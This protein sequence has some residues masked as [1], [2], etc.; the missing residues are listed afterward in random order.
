MVDGSTTM[1]S[2]MELS[3][4]KRSRGPS[5][6][7]SSDISCMSCSMSVPGGI[8]LATSATMRF[9]ASRTL[10]R[11]TLSAILVRSRAARSSLSR[12]IRWMRRRSSTETCRVPFT[13]P[14]GACAGGAL[15]ITVRARPLALP[16][17]AP[18]MG[19]SIP[20]AMVAICWPARLGALGTGGAAGAWAP[21]FTT[22]IT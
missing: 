2:E 8:S 10:G 16:W 13:G 20:G 7:A 17:V 4:M 14:A 22:R 21:C 15:G 1:I 18:G 12:I 9:N 6:S 3:A 11:I 19:G 5:P